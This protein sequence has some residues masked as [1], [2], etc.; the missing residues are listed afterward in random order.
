M[1]RIEDKAI[2]SRRG[3]ACPFPEKEFHHKDGMIK[4]IFGEAF[5]GWDNIPGVGRS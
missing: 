3:M 5:R 2:T 4:K 1:A